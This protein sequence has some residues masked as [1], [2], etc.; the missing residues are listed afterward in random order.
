MK[1][2]L[3]N[4]LFIFYSVSIFAQIDTEFWFVAPEVSSDQANFNIPI[5][6]RI[7]TLNKEAGVIIDQPANPLFVPITIDIPANFT[8][9]VDLS[10]FLELVENKPANEVLNKG[11]R[12]RSTEMVGVYYEVV[13]SYCFCN[14]EIFTLKGKNALGTYFF[15][16]FQNILNNQSFYYPTPYS[17]FDIVATENNT[18]VQIRTTNDIVGH[19][20]GVE[21]SVLLNKGQTYS[22]RA[23]SQ[24]QIYILMDE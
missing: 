20:A 10:S 17:A 7:S 15:T 11:I 18:T 8:H 22:A 1:K 4:F 6:F 21:F 19:S 5:V 3:L 13:S 9:S 24:M 16:P 23:S 12:I 14:P 2:A